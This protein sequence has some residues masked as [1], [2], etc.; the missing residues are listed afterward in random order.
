MTKFIAI[1]LIIVGIVTV[2]NMKIEPSDY[3]EETY[4]CYYCSTSSLSY[5][6]M[7]FRGSWY[8][9]S[10]R[11]TGG[12]Y[13]YA[14]RISYDYSYRN[15]YSYSSSGKVYQWDYCYDAWNT[16]R[17]LYTGKNST[18]YSSTLRS[19]REPGYGEETS[20]DYTYRNSY[21]YNSYSYRSF[22]SRVYKWD[23]TYNSWKFTNNY[24]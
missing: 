19:S 1:I 17:S 12:Y 21:S 22:D 9:S 16:S 10:L 11:A 13:D 2:T 7:P 8:S 15:S 18:W 24:G 6:Y 5:Y 3:Q 23:Y 4:D 14:N 20:Y